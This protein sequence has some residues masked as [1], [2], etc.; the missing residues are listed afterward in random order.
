[1]KNKSKLLKIENP[2]EANQRELLQLL[3]IILLYLDERKNLKFQGL[4]GL[5]STILYSGF[6]TI[7]EYTLLIRYIKDKAKPSKTRLILN[8]I[9]AF[10][11]VPS[12]EYY[13]PRGA[14]SPRVRW[15]KKQIKLIENK[16]KHN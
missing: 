4:C 1:M 16:Q 6:I 2:I 3:H 12:K 11:H 9:A 7:N 10:P 14:K 15:I 13:W 8:A 5:V